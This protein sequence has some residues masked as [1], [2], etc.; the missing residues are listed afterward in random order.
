MMCLM[1]LS[2]PAQQVSDSDD[3]VDLGL[4][5][6]TLWKSSNE[7][8]GLYTYDEA[9]SQFG[10]R[11][12]SKEQCEELKDKCQWTWNGNGYTVKGP[13]DNSIVLPAAGFRLCSGGVIEGPYGRYWT[14]SPNGSEE[15]WLLGYLSE[16]VGVG[17]NRRC[18]GF[19]VRIV[20]NGT[21]SDDY[22]DL[23]LP[24]GTLWKTSNENGFYTYDEAVSKFGD[25]L[26]SKKRWKELKNE[27]QW[28]WTGSGYKV[29]GPN[30]NSIVLPAEG[31]RALLGALS[32]VGSEGYYW[33]SRS[34]GTEY[35]WHFFFQSGGMSL[36]ESERF[37]GYSVRLVKKND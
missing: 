28:T 18:N 16:E 19:A 8:G 22:V 10:S 5:S 4:P 33:S 11:L 26:P 25:N 30:G 20:Q 14:S 35:A 36:S 24:S 32:S 31:W 15:A 29:T 23:G 13:N 37:V 6:G 12:P 21:N 17:S 1:A 2:V 3:Y 9:V 7:K 34:S 27:C